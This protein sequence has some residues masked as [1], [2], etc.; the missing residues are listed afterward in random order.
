MHRLTEETPF[1]GKKKFLLMCI[2]KNIAFLGD[3]RIIIETVSKAFIKQ[4]DIFS[5]TSETMEEFM[6]NKERWEI[7][8]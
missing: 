8:A 3:V 7:I 2:T 4:E 1:H 5:N 6:G